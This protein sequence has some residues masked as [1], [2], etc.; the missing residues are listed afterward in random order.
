MNIFPA[1]RMHISWCDEIPGKTKDFAIHFFC[2]ST[3]S[4][5]YFGAR[6]CLLLGFGVWESPYPRSISRGRSQTP[7]KKGVLWWAR[8]MSWQSGLGWWGWLQVLGG[9]ELGSLSWC[10]YNILIYNRGFLG[11]SSPWGPDTQGLSASFFP[12]LIPHLL[13]QPET[14]IVCLRALVVGT[15][16]NQD[17]THSWNINVCERRCSKNV[18]QENIHSAHLQF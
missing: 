8:A 13:T 16:E 9:R 1:V 10:F 18:S 3:N 12:L 11:L 14:N 5:P 15:G 7:K 6:L 2:H 17:F 4:G